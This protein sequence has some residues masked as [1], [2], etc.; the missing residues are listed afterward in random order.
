M[1]E[2]ITEQTFYLNLGPQH[3]STHGVLRLFLK[4]DG[5]Y[6]VEADPIVGYGH[7][8]HEKM[9]ESHLYEQFFP[10]SSRMDYLS[11]LLFN[12]AYVAAV[13]KMAGIAVPYRA[14]YIR[15]ICAELNRI[16]SHLLW[17]GTYIMDLGAFT[18]FLYAFDDREIILDILDRVTGSRLT[19]SYCRL[20]GVAKDIDEEFISSTR[21]FI[22]RLRSRWHDYHNLVTKNVIFI[23][24]TKDVG[25]IDRDLALR[26]GCTGPILRAAGVPYDIRKAEPYSVYPEFDFD[27]PTG[28]NGDA[29]DRYMVRLQE[30]EQ[31][32]R[33]IE[34]ALD[35][36][37][38]GPHKGLAPVRVSPPK[39]D[40]Y[41]AAESA[42]GALGYYIISDGSRYPYR[43]KVRVPS[44]SNL[45]VLTD[46]LPGTLVADTISILGSIDIVVPEVDR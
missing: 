30:M 25:I 3:P 27:I 9:A 10:N 20:G 22:K 37:P 23:H 8:G 26:F 29:F 44:F 14:E 16:S 28:S 1:L 12:H 13:E 24:R 33:I 18:P 2:P 17:F 46:V 15:V 36:L 39:G 43:L 42:R 31:S 7:R 38:P 41:F 21:K 19:Y 6:I 34:Q 5:E 45:Q 35:R 4:L 40:C 11:G 32:L